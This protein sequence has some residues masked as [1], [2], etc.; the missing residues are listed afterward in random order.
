MPFWLF[1]GG[2]GFLFGG[3]AGFFLAIVGVPSAAYLFLIAYYL[4]ADS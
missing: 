1:L 4:I 3:W 2:I